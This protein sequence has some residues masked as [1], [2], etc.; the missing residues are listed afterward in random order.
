MYQFQFALPLQ[1]DLEF[2]PFKGGMT[3]ATST[4]SISH[5]KLREAARQK[6]FATLIGGD[7]F[8]IFYGDKYRSHRYLSHV[9]YWTLVDLYVA[10]SSLM[11]KFCCLTAKNY[12]LCWL[13]KHQH[14]GCRTNRIRTGRVFRQ[15]L[16][17]QT[18]IDKRFP[19]G[20]KIPRSIYLST[21]KYVKE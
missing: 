13:A 14:A 15:L 9:S 20:N 17:W 1:L 10:S 16:C 21:A 19:K 12:V 6:H 11:L 2:M 7:V 8:P 3:N 4:G 18:S 5:Y